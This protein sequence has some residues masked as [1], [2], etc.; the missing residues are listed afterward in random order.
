[1]EEARWRLTLNP[2][3]CGDF[4]MKEFGQEKWLGDMF[5]GGLKELVMAIIRSR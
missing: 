2:A 1:M 3:L 5:A 4:V